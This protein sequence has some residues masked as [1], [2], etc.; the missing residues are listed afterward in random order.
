M[1]LERGEVVIPFR[2]DMKEA[3]FD[4]RKFCT[5]RGRKYGEAGDWFKLTMSGEAQKFELIA[6]RKH[7]LGY[8]ATNLFRIEGCD[9]VDGF[10]LLWEEIHPRKTFDPREEKWTHYFIPVG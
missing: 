3:V 6:V 2:D 10:I 9:S 8:V 1:G 5:T 4:R 7:T